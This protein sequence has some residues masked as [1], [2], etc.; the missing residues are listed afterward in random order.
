MY[1][2]VSNRDVVKISYLLTLWFLVHFSVQ[3]NKNS[4]LPNNHTETLSG[5]LTY[6]NW[7]TCLDKYAY[8]EV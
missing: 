8:S 7:Y 3:K 6:L 2:P 5:T 1:F 4:T